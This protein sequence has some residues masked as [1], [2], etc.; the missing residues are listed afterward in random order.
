MAAGDD[1]NEDDEKDASVATPS[2]SVRSWDNT[3]SLTPA[4][5]SPRMPASASISSKK[6][7]E[8]ATA[9]ARRNNVCTAFSLSPN[10]L[11]SN[12]GPL[13]ARKFMPDSGDRGGREG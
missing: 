6:M 5:P 9:R 13:T 12:S 3:R 7:M 11:E 2:S 1:D 10:H 8:G 4:D